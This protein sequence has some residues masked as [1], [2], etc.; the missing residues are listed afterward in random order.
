[1]IKAENIDL[2]DRYNHEKQRNIKLADN[3]EKLEEKVHERFKYEKMFNDM[4]DKLTNYQTL[5]N[6]AEL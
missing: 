5:L 2:E 1:M 4:K 6:K 3:L